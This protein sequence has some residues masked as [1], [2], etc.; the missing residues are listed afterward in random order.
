M[1]PPQLS[2]RRRMNNL[3]RRVGEGHPTLFAPLLRGAAAQIDA[4]DPLMMIADPTRLTKGLGELRRALAL[5]VIVT[6][7]PCAM[8]AQALGTSVDASAWPRR[9]VA[10]VSPDV[11][12]TEDFSAVWERS[13]ELGA[14]LEATRRLAATLGEETVMI[15]AL[16]GPATLAAELGG[17][18]M[19]EF[20]ARA[21]AA[22]TREFGQAGAAVIALIETTVPGEGWSDAITPVANV[23]KFLKM[24][25]LLAFDGVPAPATWPAQVVACP[26]PGGEAIESVHGVA[27]ARDCARWN[28][29][30]AAGARI[31]ITAGEVPPETPL[32]ALTEAVSAWQ[33]QLQA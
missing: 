20:A 22:L 9:V 19:I 16:T 13:P 1:A 23:A 8:E 2:W 30:D 29:G 11:L 4:I 18:Q 10:P 25:T 15:A 26:A 24:P 12:A 27:L 7:T 31:A 28:G 32:S 3:A 5:D 6:A 17:P 21:L 33:S 14:A